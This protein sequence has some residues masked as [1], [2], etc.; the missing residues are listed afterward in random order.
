MRR[1]AYLVI[2][3]ESHDVVAW[4]DFILN[5]T[6]GHCNSTR[7]IAPMRRMRIFMSHIVHSGPVNGVFNYALY[8]HPNLL[9]FQL[10]QTR[11]IRP[12]RRVLEQKGFHDMGI[13]LIPA[14]SD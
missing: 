13:L 4:R 14:R 10:G 3:E 9:L 6:A 5:L 11:S 7:E 12:L 1:T 2:Q 8:L